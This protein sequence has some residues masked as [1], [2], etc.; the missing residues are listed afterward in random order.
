M[1]RRPIVLFKMG[2]DIFVFTGPAGI[3]RCEGDNSDAC[4][5][6]DSAHGDIIQRRNMCTS[7]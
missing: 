1:I 4:Q 2:K 7:L 3:Y 6:A 5:Q